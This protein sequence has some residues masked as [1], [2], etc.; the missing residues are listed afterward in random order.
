M[1]I[2]NIHATMFIYMISL[3][4]SNSLKVLDPSLILITQFM[5]AFFSSFFG[6]NGKEEKHLRAALSSLS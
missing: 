4:E 6:T 2:N 5:D 1:Q 3:N